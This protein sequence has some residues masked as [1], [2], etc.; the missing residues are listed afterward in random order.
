MALLPL[1]IIVAANQDIIY[2]F[3]LLSTASSFIVSPPA[4]DA[5]RA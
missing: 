5:D 4:A 2:G 1:T 3:Y